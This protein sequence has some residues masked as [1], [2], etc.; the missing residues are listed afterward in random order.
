[1]IRTV[2]DKVLIEIE[3]VEKTTNGGIILA[4]TVEQRDH[5]GTVV[6]VGPD[7]HG[8]NIGDKVL[9]NVYS[10]LVEYGDKK[11]RVA[12]EK[13]VLAVVEG[14]PRDLKILKKES[15]NNVGWFKEDN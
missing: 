2:A 3:E 14:D 10:E 6:A 13:N 4:D 5:I 12:L 8:I 15:P 9:Y 11:Y 7:V 1:M